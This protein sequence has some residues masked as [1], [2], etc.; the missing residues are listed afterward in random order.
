MTGLSRRVPIAVERVGDFSGEEGGGR[1]LG[2]EVPKKGVVT[3]AA[4]PVLG[5]FFYCGM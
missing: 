2:L 4:G 1:K 5:G 3:E